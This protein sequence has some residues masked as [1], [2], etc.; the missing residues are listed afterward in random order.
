MQP[1]SNAGASLA[2]L[3]LMALALIAAWW[4]PNRPT[5]GNVAMPD[6]KFESLSYAPYRPGQ[7]PLTDNFP[8]TAEVDQDLT[9]LAAHSLGI[10]SYSSV[11]GKFNLPALARRHH[12][13][14]WLGIWLSADRAANAREMA[15]GIAAAR[16]YPDVVD[17]VVVGNEVLLR[18]DLPV[19]ELI[20][21]I[22]AVKRAVPEKVTT[23]DVWEDFLRYPQIVPYLDIVTVHIL[24][25]WEDRPTDLAG[26]MK[27]V[28]AVL[29]ELA[30]R[31]PGK[32]LAIGE[33]GWPSRGRWRRDAAPSLVN[34]AVYLRRFIDLADRLH[35]DYNIIEAFDQDWKYHNEGTVGAN[36]G[37][38]TDTRHLK[39]PLFGPVR[40]NPDWGTDAALS[41]LCGLALAGLATL[42]GVTPARAVMAMALGG[43]M[44]FAIAGT[45]PVLYDRFAAIAGIANM[46]GQ[47]VL[48]CLFVLRDDG[49]A[50][51]GKAATEA[52]R[53]VLRLRWPAA[54]RGPVGA[55]ALCDDLNFLFLWTAAILQVLLAYDPRYRDFPLP[56]FAVP[57]VIAAIRLLR[58]RNGS[59]LRR[60]DYVVMA[61][62]L[63][64]AI[65]SAVQ[66]G[67]RNLQSLIWNGAACLLVV[68]RWLTRQKCQETLG[69]N[70]RGK[71]ATA[72]EA[73]F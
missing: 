34:E 22:L 28:K 23:A 30:A 27:H 64:G 12:L 61:M 3:A 25:Y 42:R 57:V 9:L 11:E 56:T 32:K 29:T 49:P 2:A 55:D 10:R 39:F 67:P 51:D 62:L 16:A 43:A 63:G 15:A 20:A 38:W 26:S 48:A 19:A 59:H 7:S 37:I 33:T 1:K 17:R 68:E 35:V 36:W 66:E 24:P 45:A 72:K 71:D 53:S 4:W 40:E 14:L 44:G 31:F 73:T 46:L 8:T 69:A 60:A 50:R 58:G 13:K 18:H 5:A 54:W 65:F 47:A 41:V 21:D 52:F 70:K 6:A